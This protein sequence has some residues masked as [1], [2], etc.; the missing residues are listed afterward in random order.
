MTI[1]W[2]KM[3]NTN[4]APSDRYEACHALAN[5]IEQFGAALPCP[6]GVMRERMVERTLEV[7]NE[8]VQSRLGGPSDYEP[9]PETRE[10]DDDTAYFLGEH[11][12]FAWRLVAGDEGLQVQKQTGGGTEPGSDLW[13][14]IQREDLPAS[15]VEACSAAGFDLDA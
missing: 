2:E 4:L 11:D 6:H 13:T 7:A 1:L 15:V 12:G 14:T 3:L 10:L 5:A 9:D 8:V